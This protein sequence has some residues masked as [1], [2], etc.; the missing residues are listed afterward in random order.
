MS[1]VAATSLASA[2]LFPGVSKPTLVLFSGSSS[3]S[4]ALR[5]CFAERAP[6]LSLAACCCSSRA[7]SLSS[8]S[9]FLS[10]L[11]SFLASPVATAAARAAATTFIPVVVLGGLT[12]RLLPMAIPLSDTMTAGL[13]MPFRVSTSVA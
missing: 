13:G 11:S 1:L 7:S 12:I 6:P 4:L 3:P 9:S 10:R 8:F 5:P 2:S